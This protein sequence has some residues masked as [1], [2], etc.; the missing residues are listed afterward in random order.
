MSS[1]IE[2]SGKYSLGIQVVTELIMIV[3]YFYVFSVDTTTYV[4]ILK[5]LLIAELF[6]Q[7]IEAIFYIWMVYNISKVKNI[8]IFRYYDWMITTPTML[9]TLIFYLIFLRYVEKEGEKEEKE[10]STPLI[11]NYTYFGMLY[12]NFTNVVII[13]LLN[14]SMLIFG[15]AGEIKMLSP[16]VSTFFGF[17]PF[18][19]MFYLI[20]YNYAIH[21]QSGKEIF[22]YFS[23]VWSIY[24]I[25][26]VMD[27][28]T[29]NVMYNILDLFAKNFFGV[30]LSY[31]IIMNTYK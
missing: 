5:E 27:Y 25:A 20:Y 10:E 13:L 9:I 21:T 1:I 15:Y 12:E 30:F 14:W 22:W 17:I 3:A 8:T 4:N 23:I 7:T 28:N 31:K 29:K 6:V 16:L 19:M 18:F 26:A 24:G 11:Q 2:T